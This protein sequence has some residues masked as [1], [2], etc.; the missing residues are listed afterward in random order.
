MKVKVEVEGR[1]FPLKIIIG[2]LLSSFSVGS[3]GKRGSLTIVLLLHR[4]VN[5]ER[6]GGQIPPPHE[7]FGRSF[8]S[9]PTRGATYA[10]YIKVVRILKKR[11]REMSHS[12]KVSRTFEFLRVFGAAE[13]IQGK[14]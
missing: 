9:I 14:F 12:G 2:Y 4:A 7:V 10:H 1:G 5:T 11:A 8:N 13:K 3:I 6:T